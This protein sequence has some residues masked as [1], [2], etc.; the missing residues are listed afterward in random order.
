MCLIPFP[1]RHFSNSALVKFPPLSLT[2]VSEREWV[3]KISLSFIMVAVDVVL[4]MM[5]T[6][7]HFKCA[8]VTNK[9]L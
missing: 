9:Y 2:M 5:W 8:T 3:A 4:R 6:P 7:I 1:A